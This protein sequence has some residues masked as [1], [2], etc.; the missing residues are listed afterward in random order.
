MPDPSLLE[1]LNEQESEVR[2]EVL[3]LVGGTGFAWEFVVR[4]GSPGEEI[5]RL[6]DEVGADLVVVGSNRHSALH[7]LFLGSTAAYLATHSRVPVLVTRSQ[8]AVTAE[9][10][11][12]GALSRKP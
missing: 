2:Q 4:V 8:A 5:V 3:R 10:K 9:T 1:A 6:A 7:N 12:A 11:S